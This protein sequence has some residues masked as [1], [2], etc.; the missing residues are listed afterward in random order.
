LK[1]SLGSL[2]TKIDQIKVAFKSIAAGLIEGFVPVLELI[3]RAMTS[4]AES[5]KNMNPLFK[6]L[7]AGFLGVTA[8]I[9]PLVFA[10]G[11]M[12]L[13]VSTVL[14]TLLKFA[15]G[16][17]HLTAEGIV[18]APALLRLTK[19]I[20]LA[21]ESFETT[22]SKMGLMIAKLASMDSP[23]GR[24]A[25][26]FGELT[27]VLRKVSTVAPNVAAEIDL[28]QQSLAQAS[29]PSKVARVGGLGGLSS[30]GD[31]ASDSSPRRIRRSAESIPFN[32]L[33]QQ[34]Y[35]QLKQQAP[36]SVYPMD[37]DQFNKP[38]LPSPY[39]QTKGGFRA[40]FEKT[41]KPPEI[42]SPG[43]FRKQYLAKLHPH[44]RNTKNVAVLKAQNKQIAK[45]W[46]ALVS[47]YKVDLANHNQ[48]I[49]K[50]WRSISSAHKK[51]VDQ[52]VNH[53]RYQL[54]PI[55]KAQQVAGVVDL[56]MV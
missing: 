52:M 7:I 1:T 34:K 36:N 37:V 14:G 41:N 32:S 9:G 10:F 18:A 53:L 55:Q 43:A 48:L 38:L 49:D 19:P 20:I 24:L 26:R 35:L 11:Q 13:V 29:N 28:V 5:F 30:L 31:P 6:V 2:K 56:E 25:N 27:G 33:V 44:A 45:E 12:K 40:M 54:I 16:L 47:K 15:P 39:A 23:I 8:M 42:M 51:Q 22:T 17:S 3:K 4:L 21:G 46:N 50:G